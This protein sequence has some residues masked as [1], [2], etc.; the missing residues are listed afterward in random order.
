MIFSRV[1][2]YELLQAMVELSFPL[3][4]TGNVKA[5]SAEDFETVTVVTYQG[6]FRSS[7]IKLY[8]VPYIVTN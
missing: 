5:L 4:L 3:G 1:Y 8:T 6:S 7:R 2:I